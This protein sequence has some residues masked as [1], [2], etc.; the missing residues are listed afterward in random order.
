MSMVKPVTGWTE[1]TAEFERSPV[2]MDVIGLTGSGRTSL[3]MSA[4]GPLA[5]MHSAEK[6]QGL[7]QR[8]VREGKRVREYKFGFVASGDPKRDQEAA[9]KVWADLRKMYTDALTTWAGTCIFDTGNEAWENLRYAKFGVLTPRGNRMDALWGPVNREMRSLWADEFRGQD[10]CNLIT[11]HQMGNKWKDVVKDGVTKSVETDKIVRKGGFKEVPAMAD[12][13][14]QTW[15]GED[16]SFNATIVK[17][18]F[19]AST[20]GLPLNEALMQS[21]GYSGLNFSSIMAFITEL[22]EEVWL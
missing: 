17:G 8:I 19:N 20:E 2:Y 1:V 15:R 9:A 5:L 7:K 13:I 22:G 11:I 18:W 21:L 16:M 12:V 14:V 6:V 3:A 10:R 4:P